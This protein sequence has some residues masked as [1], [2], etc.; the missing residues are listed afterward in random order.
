MKRRIQI[1]IATVM[2]SALVAGTVSTAFAAKS[3]TQGRKPV[4]QNT[5]V[6]TQQ[7]GIAPTVNTK[8]D[9]TASITRLEEN[10]QKVIKVSSTVVVDGIT[11]TVT[12]ISA[13]AFADCKRMKRVELPDT[14]TEIGARA[15]LGAKKLKRIEFTSDKAPKISK[16]A[17]EGV[18]T[19]KMTIT[20]PKEMEKKEITKFK[21]RLKKA[22]FEG[23]VKKSKKAKEA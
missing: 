3:P 13:R 4:M 10:E 14:I 19:R 5:V 18:D 12:R 21:K 7:A 11:Y 6:A 16:K 8:E 1:L 22:K 15:F 17:F 2:A 23:K 20:Y 9:G